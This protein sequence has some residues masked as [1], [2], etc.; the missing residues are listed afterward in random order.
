MSVGAVPS[1]SNAAYTS[2]LQSTERSAFKQRQQ[3]F[4]S[5]A[6]ALSA[7]DLSGAQTAFAAL[8]QDLKNAGPAPAVQQTG[9]IQTS[10]NSVTTA[11]QALGQALNSG[12]LSSAQKAFAQ[13]QQ[14]IQQAAQGHRHHHHQAGASAPGGSAST[15]SI[16]SA[17]SSTGSNV[18]TKA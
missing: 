14:D 7:G 13:L 10:Q 16:T 6:Q 18:D 3:D 8:Q 2:A 5:L 15:P 4:Q 12:D 17:S 11:L 1:T 9:S